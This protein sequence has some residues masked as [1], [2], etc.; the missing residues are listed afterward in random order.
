M[1]P[2]S[3]NRKEFILQFYLSLIS[4]NIVLGIIPNITF[5]NKEKMREKKRARRQGLAFFP[6]F[7]LNIW[8][9]PLSKTLLF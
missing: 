5:I 8:V 6:L 4:F 7:S 9:S 2:A 1:Y 3:P